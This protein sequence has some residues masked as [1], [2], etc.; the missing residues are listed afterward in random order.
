MKKEIPSRITQRS[1]CFPQHCI[2]YLFWLFCSNL[3][4]AEEGGDSH[5]LLKHVF[6]IYVNLKFRHFPSLDFFLLLHV[7]SVKRL[8]GGWYRIFIKGMKYLNLPAFPF[9]VMSVFLTICLHTRWLRGR[10]C[11][12]LPSLHLLCIHASLC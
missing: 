4:I 2:I 9:R 6:S 8:K 5:V 7:S 11:T 1:W 10:V 12:G 3:L